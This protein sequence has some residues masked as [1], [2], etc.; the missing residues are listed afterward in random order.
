MRWLIAVFVALLV[1]YLI[2]AIVSRVAGQRALGFF[3]RLIARIPM[4]ETVYSAAKK[5]IDV[6][7]QPAGGGQ[8]VV[9]IDFPS[10]GMKTLGF[11]MRTFPDA[12]TGEELAASTCRRR[13]TRPA[14]SCRSLAVVEAHPRRHGARPGDD[15]DHLR[16]R[17]GTGGADDCGWKEQLTPSFSK[18]VMAGLVVQP[19]DIVDTC[20][21]T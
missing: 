5:L 2:G 19:G 11:V 17:G 6:M 4:V 16:R 13:S 7:R 10:E 1:L 18:V 8:R 12:K 15:D 20:S 14:A 9:L 21:E 3:E